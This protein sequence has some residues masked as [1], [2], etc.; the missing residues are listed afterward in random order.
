MLMYFINVAETRSY[1]DKLA[2]SPQP[3]TLFSSPER[4]KWNMHLLCVKEQP[5]DMSLTAVL[6]GLDPHLSH[7]QVTVQH[8]ERQSHPAP[9]AGVNRRVSAGAAWDLNNTHGVASVTKT[10]TS[11]HVQSQQL[12]F[13]LQVQVSASLYEHLH[14][15]FISCGRGVHQ[16]SHSLQEQTVQSWFPLIILVR[17]CKTDVFL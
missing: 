4:L 13:Y 2:V 7:R 6:F 16:R 17:L 15:S 10:L 1:D 12:C 5:A 8:S 11:C 14:Q 9:T 3:K